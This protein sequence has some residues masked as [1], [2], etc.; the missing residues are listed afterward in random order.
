MYYL[1]DK[2][3]GA[4]WTGWFWWA[5]SC[6]ACKGDGHYRPTAADRPAGFPLPP[7]PPRKHVGCQPRKHVGCQMAVN[8][9]TAELA[10]ESWRKHQKSQVQESQFVDMSIELA[11]QRREFDQLLAAIIDSNGG[12]VKISDRSRF[13]FSGPSINPV[14]ETID[15]KENRRQII[16]FWQQ[17]SAAT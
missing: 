10:Y 16:R 8:L 5:K 11:K 14:F 1:C 9:R 4:G 3:G 12:S 6:T 13:L 2:C 15:D 7:P 17:E